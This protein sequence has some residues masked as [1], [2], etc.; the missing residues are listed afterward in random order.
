MVLDLA[1][2]CVLRPD[3]LGA[4]CAIANRPIHT[5]NIINKDRRMA[6]SLTEKV[7]RLW[8]ESNTRGHVGQVTVVAWKGNGTPNNFLLFSNLGIEK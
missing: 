8:A 5:H 6:V 7:D 3:F 2:G 4:A 1:P